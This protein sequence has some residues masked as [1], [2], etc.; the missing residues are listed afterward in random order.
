MSST[1]LSS[2]RHPAVAQPQS[3]VLFTWTWRLIQLVHGLCTYLAVNP[4]LDHLHCSGPVESTQIAWVP[5]F[6]V[7]ILV[8]VSISAK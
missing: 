6:V 2:D 7:P 5:I 8:W 4:A 3:P 1:S